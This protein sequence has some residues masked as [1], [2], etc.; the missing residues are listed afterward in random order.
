MLAA[1]SPAGTSPAANSP[2]AAPAA[3]PA[4][5]PGVALTADQTVK[6]PVFPVSASRLREIDL[7]IKKLTK[8]IEREKTALEKSSLDD[9][10]N[11]EKISKTAALFGG[12]ST[13]QRDSVTAVR[14]ESLEKEL[15]LLDKL[16]TPLTQGDRALIEKLIEDQLAYRRGLDDL[17]R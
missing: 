13:T 2:D 11:D 6:L 10:L 17:L 14:I 1:Y 5:A 12:K 4:P 3:R 8:Q 7:R 9:T 15:D 16:R